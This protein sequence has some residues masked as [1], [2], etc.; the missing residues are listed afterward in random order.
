MAASV[1]AG[2]VNSISR[3]WKQRFTVPG[4]RSPVAG[5]APSDRKKEKARAVARRL[6]GGDVRFREQ[7]RGRADALEEMIEA[8]VLVGAVLAVVRVG[9]RDEQRGD[10]Q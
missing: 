7:L 9:V 3:S 10:L 2:K 5:R 4:A 8:Q 1:S 6:R